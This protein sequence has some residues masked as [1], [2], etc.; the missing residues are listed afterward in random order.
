MQMSL[1]SVYEPEKCKSANANEPTQCKMQNAIKNLC[2]DWPFAWSWFSWL[3]SRPSVERLLQVGGMP[4]LAPMSH[5]QNSG[6]AALTENIQHKNW[7]MCI[8][9]TLKIFSGGFFPTKGHPPT[10]ERKLSFAKKIGRNWFVHLPLPNKAAK[11]A[12]C[13]PKMHNN[14]RHLRGTRHTNIALRILLTTFFRDSL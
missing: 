10:P 3:I 1:Q 7:H 11:I 5:F 12:F 13:S 8:K 6:E 9:G 2:Q 4:L 14:L